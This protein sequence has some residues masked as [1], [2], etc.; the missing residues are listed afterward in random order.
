MRS[1]SL[2]RLVIASLGVSV[3][4]TPGCGE[5]ATAPSP[6]TA[7]VAT[8]SAV[9]VEFGGRVV[10]ADTG[11]PVGNVQVS[12]V[13]IR[14][15]PPG[16]WFRP[17]NPATSGADGT[18]TLPL[19]LP[20]SWTAVH[21][22]LTGPGYDHRDMTVEATTA[23]DRPAIRMYR[24]LVIRPGESITVRVDTGIALCGESPVVDCR[25]VLVAGS[26]GD[27]VELELAPDDSSEPMGLIPDD[28]VGAYPPVRRLMVPPA[29][30][31]YVV[32]AG[33]ATLTARR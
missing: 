4:I 14:F 6:P 32:G 30:S 7:T 9:T 1:R 17:N 26:P 5:P 18:F 15:P 20:S 28:Y 16:G 10:D 2:A 13:G 33:T 3:V 12:L 29:I 19:N 22:G 21:L 25:R 11:G 8:V 23:A 31:P 27:P 24:T